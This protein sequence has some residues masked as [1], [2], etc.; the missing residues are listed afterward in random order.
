MAD[1]NW[2]EYPIPWQSLFGFLVCVAVVPVAYL[3]CGPKRPLGNFAPTKTTVPCD[4][5]RGPSGRGNRRGKR[6]TRGVINSWNERLS[7]TRPASPEN[8]DSFS[9]SLSLRVVY[10]GLTAL[11]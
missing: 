8:S 9:L 10:L 5:R 4:E 3:V 6:E 7:L 11:V 2:A 1:D